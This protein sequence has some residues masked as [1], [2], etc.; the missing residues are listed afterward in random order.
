M[1]LTKHLLLGVVATVWLSGCSLFNRGQDV[2]QKAPLPSVQNQIEPNLIWYASVGNGAAGYYSLLHPAWL[3]QSV[4]AAARSGVVKALDINDGKKRWQIDLQEKQGLFS[5]SP[6]ALL[7]GGIAA[8]GDRLY[9]GSERGYVYA[10]EAKTGAVAWRTDVKGEATSTPVVSEG[11]VLIH[12]SNGLLQAL[13]EKSGSVKWSVNLDIPPL[14]LRGQSAPAVAS[15][16]ALVGGNNGRV[17]VVILNKGQIAWNKR[18]S[19]DKGTS[20]ISR[21]GDIIAA[22]VIADGVLYA[23]AYNGNLAALEMRSGQ[24]L[25]QRDIGGVRNFTIN[26]GV[27]YLVDQDDRVIACNA[28]DG[29]V[30]WRQSDLLHRQLTSPAFYKGYLVVGDSEGYLHWLG[31]ADGHFSA[32]MKGDSS[33]FQSDPLVADSLLLIQANS[34]K[35]YAFSL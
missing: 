29:A 5:K 10:L 19:N 7:S 33:G 1:K 17:S 22:P 32:Q 30:I 9:L 35:V 23:Q 14:T 16:G 3:N 28:R 13:D 11:L 34:G 18:I 31:T 21:L 4:F 20:D 6:A 2:V 26:N 27:I 24:I 25:W 8:V 15:G 12:T